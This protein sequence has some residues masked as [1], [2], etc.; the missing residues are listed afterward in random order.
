MSLDVFPDDSRQDAERVR[1]FFVDRWRLYRKV[2]TLDYLSHRD[3]YAALG[4]A[5]KG[6]RAPF[7]FLDLGA[8]DADCTTAMLRELPVASYE[9]VDLSTVALG[10]AEENADR[11]SCPK[12][13]TEAD[14]AE[15]IANDSCGTFDV[16]FIGLSLHHLPTPDKAAFLPKLRSRLA[17]GGSFF[18]YE[19]IRGATE[20]RRDVMERWWAHAQAEWTA[21]NAAELEE[22][23]EHIFEHDYPEPLAGYEAMA[24][25]AGF[26]DFEV[27]YTSPGD[28][29]A[30]VRAST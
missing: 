11:L 19:P 21:L 26:R 6:V 5:L 10:L 14:F 7:S 17:E 2:L 18:F 24:R 28:F 25:A 30:L 22:V 13:F 16:I 8:G 15:Y 29:Y 27:L 12:R 23:R 1:A 9:A 3:A 20:S 4:A